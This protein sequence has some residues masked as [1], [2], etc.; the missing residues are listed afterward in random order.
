MDSP[1]YTLEVL[2]HLPSHL[3]MQNQVRQMIPYGY[4]AFAG[5]DSLTSANIASDSATDHSSIST[6]GPSTPV[7][8]EQMDSSS[9]F[10]P[11]TRWT[12]DLSSPYYT[13]KLWFGTVKSGAEPTLSSDYSGN[14]VK[15]E[16]LGGSDDGSS[17]AT[18]ELD[19]SHM[20]LPM[21]PKSADTVSSIQ[22]HLKTELVDD[23]PSQQY[24][25]SSPS[26][27]A[28]DEPPSSFELDH[29]AQAGFDT[30]FQHGIRDLNWM[31]GQEYKTTGQETPAWSGTRG[32]Q[33][34]SSRKQSTASGS[35]LVN[36]VERAMVNCD[37]PG[38]HKV[39]RRNEH[40]KRHKQTFHGEGLNRFSCEFCGKDQFNR[41]DNLNNH[42]KLHTRPKSGSR[43]VQF[44]AAAVP[45]I[46]Q[47]E[48]SRKRRAP[49]GAKA[50]AARSSLADGPANG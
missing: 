23:F 16:A 11:D 20:H 1:P 38:C 26:T 31:P 15:Q 3:G 39:Y 5:F 6:S 19:H 2:S 8:L 17:W 48:R 49:S 14:P 36:I 12:Y 25:S 32:A 10:Y 7:A 46:E 24:T 40:L 22:R 45:V 37:Y 21:D 41:Q 34:Q 18:F 42:R 13:D 33:T 44:I 35:V 4:H 9:V 29:H 27:F 28:D 50:R 43:G 47:E 30:S